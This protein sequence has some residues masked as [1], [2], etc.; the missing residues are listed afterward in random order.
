VAQKF[1]AWH[2]QDAARP[3]VVDGLLFLALSPCAARVGAFVA[4]VPARLRF[5]FATMVSRRRASGHRSPTS[6]P[7]TCVMPAALPIFWSRWFPFPMRDIFRWRLLFPR[8]SVSH[9]FHVV[10]HFFNLFLVWWPMLR[11]GQVDGSSSGSC[12]SWQRWQAPISPH[13]AGFRPASACRPTWF[14]S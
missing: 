10:V 9:H 11:L 7:G 1:A 5:Y 3:A 12:K 13:F 8:S 2:K 6:P 14:L 4:P